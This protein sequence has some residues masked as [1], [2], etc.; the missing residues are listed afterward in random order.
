MGLL[1]DFKVD[2]LLNSLGKFPTLEEENQLSSNYQI[3]SLI[4]HLE[5]NRRVF[6]GYYYNNIPRKSTDRISNKIYGNQKQLLINTMNEMGIVDTQL[7]EFLMDSAALESSY[8]LNSSSKASTASGWFGFLDSTKVDILSQMNILKF[9]KNESEK[10]KKAKARAIFN[11]NPKVQVAAAIQ[12]YNN[13]IKQTSKNKVLNAAAFR[14][15]SQNEVVHA[16]WL[17]PKWAKEY[18]LY[19]R[20]GGT[21]AFGTSVEKYIKKIRGIK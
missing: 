9:D 7:R 14:G 4:N 5:N 13:I 15:F 16:Y 6:D 1:Q 17:N 8:K 2:G 20:Q 10:Q 18:F 11:N 12:L 19:G 3:P 21:D